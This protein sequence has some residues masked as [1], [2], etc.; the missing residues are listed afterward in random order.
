VH[1]RKES[2]RWSEGE[3]E[4]EGTHATCQILKRDEERVGNA[5]GEVVIWRTVP[6]PC[7]GD[8]AEVEGICKAIGKTQVAGFAGEPVRHGKQDK[9]ANGKWG[10]NQWEGEKGWGGGCRG[11][12]WR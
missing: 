12:G 6:N 4:G 2:T 5:P 9:P 8:D 3:G 1:T 10:A 11:Q 7:H